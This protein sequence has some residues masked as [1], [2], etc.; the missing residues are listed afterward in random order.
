MV[1]PY[2]LPLEVQNLVLGNLPPSSLNPALNQIFNRDVLEE[3]YQKIERE[4]PK[5][6][7]RKLAYFAEKG[8]DY[9]IRKR[10]D[11]KYLDEGL[12]H[13]L[14]FELGKKGNGRM[15]RYLMNH[16]IL[17]IDDAIFGAILSHHN[18][19]VKELVTTTPVYN[20]DVFIQACLDSDNL[21]IMKF[22]AI[23]MELY[24]EH[25]VRSNRTTYWLIEFYHYI[26]MLKFRNI[27]DEG[28]STMYRTGFA[29]AENYVLDDPQHMRKAVVDAFCSDLREPLPFTYS[30]LDRFLPP[31]ESYL[32][33][34]SHVNNLLERK[35]RNFSRLEWLLTNADQGYRSR[36]ETLAMHDT[37]WIF[38]LFKLSVFPEAFPLFQFAKRYLGPRWVLLVDPLQSERETNEIFEMM[39]LEGWFENYFPV[40]L[41]LLTALVPPLLNSEIYMSMMSFVVS[42]HPGRAVNTWYHYTG[43]GVELYDS[44]ISRFP[45]FDFH[46]AISKFFQCDP[47]HTLSL[48]LKYQLLDLW[49]EFLPQY[50]TRVDWKHVYKILTHYACEGGLNEIVHGLKKIIS[51]HNP[52]YGVSSYYPRMFEESGIGKSGK[53]LDRK[54]LV[55][56]DKNRN[57]ITAAD[58][59]LGTAEELIARRL[60]DQE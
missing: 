19:L 14:L 31:F 43:N 23:R 48:L 60:R 34:V 26:G 4:A 44:S 54:M 47:V 35:S 2:T 8:F 5:P 46:G 28:S 27:Y 3:Q 51:P 45:S 24:P 49:N 38:H 15:I 1:S 6:L 50:Q 10:L 33:M 21:E 20:T 58:N 39:P 9:G 12:S 22:L 37:E 29:I 56:T 42:Q 36:G 59:K 32:L 57:A 25:I 55:A 52:L 53:N 17:N 11:G 41:T 30:Q 40:D 7:A 16:G 13:L 18:N